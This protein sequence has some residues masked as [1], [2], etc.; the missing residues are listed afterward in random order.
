LPVSF[1]FR[2][3]VQILKFSDALEAEEFPHILAKLEEKI[4]QSRLQI[5]FHLEAFKNEDDFSKSKV[6]Q[7]IRFCYD[8]KVELVLCLPNKYW[9][10]YMIGTQTLAKMFATETE[11]ISYFVSLGDANAPKLDGVDAEKMRD[12]DLLIKKYESFHQS[13]ELDPYHLQKMKRLYAV[14]P[15]LEAIEKLEKASVDILQRKENIGRLKEQCEQLSKQAFLMSASRTIP[16][17]DA[18][19]ILNQKEIDA[20][21]VFLSAIE[22][23][24]ETQLRE[25][26][27]EHQKI[28]ARILKLE[29]IDSA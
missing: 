7:L 14:T 4:L 23:G 10:R 26:Q 25:H 3:N 21:M 16:L 12:T 13:D 17:N 24:M 29:A 9:S 28:D 1:S 5:L 2:N 11:A 20:Q 22:S 19:F 8:K 18:E 6:I 15:T 27:L